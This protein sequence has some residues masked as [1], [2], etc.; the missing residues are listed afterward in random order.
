ML[1]H[2]HKFNKGARR[3]CYL[4]R[5]D[6]FTF[7]RERVALF[8]GVSDEHLTEIATGSTVSSYKTGQTIL[9]KGVTVDAL[10]V[11][12]TG[13]AGVW[14]KPPTQPI[15]EVAVLS[16]GEVFGETSIIEN[17]TAGATIKAKED[18]TFILVIPQDA[19]RKLL[20]DSPEFVARVKALI[21]SRKSA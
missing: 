6:A 5:M 12:C 4:I 1:G 16:S 7:L 11:V 18:N 21:A 2:W 14:V 20:A 9:F 15:V 13:S 19:F 8:A 10:H 17:G 3:F